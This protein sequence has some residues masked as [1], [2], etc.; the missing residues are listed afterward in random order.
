MILLFFKVFAFK[1]IR[2]YIHS[3]IRSN[4]F[5]KHFSHYEAVTSEITVQN[6]STA[7]DDSN[8]LLRI[9]FLILFWEQK[10]IIR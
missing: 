6:V 10:E 5:S 9:L 4:Q 1:I 8:R 3:C 7:S 2:I